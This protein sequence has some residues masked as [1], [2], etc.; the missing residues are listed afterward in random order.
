MSETAR[1]PDEETK[2]RAN[3]AGFIY[4]VLAVAT[5]TAAE[6][7]R[8][9]SYGKLLAAGAVALALY[10]LAHAYS[11]HWGARLTGQPHWSLREFID[12]LGHES[13]ILAGAAL[14]LAVLLVDWLAGVSLETGV[15]A[16]LWTAGVEVALLEVA[17][18]LRRR[19]G[20]RDLLVQSAIGMAFGLG[21]LG[22]RVLL[23]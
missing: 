1:Q 3:P 23:H 21:I 22:L 11:R 2:E 16:V 5:V 14:P 4:G 19:L 12:A 18:G 7:T 6:R 13:P 10:W 8:Q 17:V 15:T 20:T 9:E